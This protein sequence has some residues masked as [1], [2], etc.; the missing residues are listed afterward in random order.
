MD[1]PDLSEQCLDEYPLLQYSAEYLFT[2][3]K[4]IER[5][6]VKVQDVIDRSYKLF[7]QDS[8]RSFLN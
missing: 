3:V 7:S 4:K 6:N 8:A 1:Q 2:H 5:D